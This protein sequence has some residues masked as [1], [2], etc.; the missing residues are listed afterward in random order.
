MFNFTRIAIDFASRYCISRGNGTKPDP[1]WWRIHDWWEF[2]YND[3]F[4]FWTV[5]VT[6]TAC[7]WNHSKYVITWPEADHTTRGRFHWFTLKGD[8]WK[9]CT[10]GGKE[11][12]LT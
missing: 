7:G 8:F 2:L 11:L 1:I 6:R 3:T 5:H 9:G 12:I 10:R 4:T